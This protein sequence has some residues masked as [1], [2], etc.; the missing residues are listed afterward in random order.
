MNRPTNKEWPPEII[1]QQNIQTNAPRRPAIH[2]P[3]QVRCQ[4]VYTDSSGV[5]RATVQAIRSG[6]KYPNII[7][8]GQY[9]AVNDWGFVFFADADGDAPV[10]ISLQD[11]GFPAEAAIT[12]ITSTSPVEATVT[13]AGGTVY[14]GVK[15]HGP[16][17]YTLTGN[18]TSGYTLNTVS[19]QTGDFGILVAP[20][21]PTKPIFI[22]LRS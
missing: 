21:D 9:P 2:N 12:T 11:H 3:L 4:A 17:Q 5:L 8:Q 10:F 18:L 14:K 19:Y 16:M 7:V 1:P 20:G 6:I 22:D 15:V 13:T